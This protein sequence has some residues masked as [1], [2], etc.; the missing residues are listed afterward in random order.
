M[1]LV[2]SCGELCGC[3]PYAMGTLGVQQEHGFAHESSN[4]TAGK[5]QAL[6][7]GR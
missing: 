7:S 1:Y 3:I 5:N 6:T 4:K 2:D